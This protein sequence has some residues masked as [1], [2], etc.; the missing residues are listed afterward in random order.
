MVNWTGIGFGVA[1]LPHCTD[2]DGQ[3]NKD[4]DSATAEAKPVTWLGQLNGTIE[5]L[6]LSM[7]HVSVPHAPVDGFTHSSPFFTHT[8]PWCGFCSAWSCTRRAAGGA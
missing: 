2:Y 6:M 8:T 1:G 4:G 3:G 7:T 5:S